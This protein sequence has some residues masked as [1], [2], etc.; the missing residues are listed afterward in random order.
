MSEQVTERWPVEL[1]V[2]RRLLVIVRRCLRFH[3]K[4]C[5]TCRDVWLGGQVVCLEGRQLENDIADVQ[6]RVSQFTLPVNGD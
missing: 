3:R 1:I 5:P 4:T 2:A 6:D